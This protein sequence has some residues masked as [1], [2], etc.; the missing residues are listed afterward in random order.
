[1]NDEIRDLLAQVG[2]L[3]PERFNTTDGGNQL[4][5]FAELLIDE[6]CVDELISQMRISQVNGDHDTVTL[7]GDLMDSIRSR[8]QED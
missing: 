3:Q 4:V 2:I 1:M 8:L 6:I 7:L 5:R